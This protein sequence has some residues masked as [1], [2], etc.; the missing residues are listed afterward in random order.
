MSTFGLGYNSSGLRKSDKYEYTVIYM[1]QEII[2]HIKLTNLYLSVS[3][4]EEIKM[5]DVED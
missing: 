5:E 4:G 2:S 3:I 1:L